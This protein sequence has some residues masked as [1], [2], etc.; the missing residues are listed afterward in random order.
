MGATVIVTSSSD[1]KPARAK[2]L[3]AD[4]LINYRDQ[5]GCSRP[6]KVLTGGRGVDLVIDIGGAGTL[7]QSIRVVRVGGT[8]AMIGVVAGGVRVSGATATRGHA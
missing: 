7:E 4:H 1:E 8:I 5:P 2:E 3:R 6:V